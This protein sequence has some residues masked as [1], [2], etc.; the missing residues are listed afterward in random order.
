MTAKVAGSVH[1]F[2]IL[3]LISRGEEDDIKYER[4][5]T[6]PTPM[7]LFLIIVRGDGD[8]TPNIAGVVHNACDIVSDIRGGGEKIIF[9]PILQVVYTPPEIWHR[10]SKEGEDGIHTNIE[11]CVHAPYD[12]VFSIQWAGG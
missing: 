1:P 2:L 11:V 6:S 5:C 4:G 3:F 12:M 8:I 7:I 10:I 9:L